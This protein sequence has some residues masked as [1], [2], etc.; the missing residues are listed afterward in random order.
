MRTIITTY[1]G[2]QDLPAGIKRMLVVSEDFF[3]QEIQSQAAKAK[4]AQSAQ[5]EAARR[6]I[7]RQTEGD[8]SVFGPDWRN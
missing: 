2:F 4:T 1:P 3:F 6:R 5:R 7:R 8:L